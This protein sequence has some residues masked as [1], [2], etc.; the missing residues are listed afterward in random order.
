MDWL[1]V[2]LIFVLP[3]AGLTLFERAGNS[4]LLVCVLVMTSI[5]LTRMYN[6]HTMPA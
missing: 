5:I 4:V 1:W 6:R 2:A 3:W